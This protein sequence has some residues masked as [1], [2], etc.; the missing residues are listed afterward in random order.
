MVTDNYNFCFFLKYEELE[1]IEAHGYR[2]VPNEKA[3]DDF[4]EAFRLLLEDGAEK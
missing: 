4:C 3:I 1:A 2:T